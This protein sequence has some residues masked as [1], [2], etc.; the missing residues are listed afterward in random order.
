MRLYVAH[1]PFGLVHACVQEIR[2]IAGCQFIL[3]KFQTTCRK[4]ERGF[5][6]KEKAFEKGRRISKLVGWLEK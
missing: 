3:Q 4:F 5:A 2:D 1:V 6:K